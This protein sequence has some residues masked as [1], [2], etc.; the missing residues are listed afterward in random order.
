V[1]DPGIPQAPPR[2]DTVRL[3]ARPGP[4]RLEAMRA[5]L[6]TIEACRSE[7]AGRGANVVSE[8][9][10]GQGT[11]YEHDHYP[12]G[13]VY[14][15]SSHAQYYYHAHRG[16]GGEHGH[17]HCFL[18]APGMPPGVA[19]LDHPGGAGW[20]QGADAIAHLVAIAMDGDGRPTRLFTT[21]RWVTGET[22]YPAGDV[23]A[24]LDRFRIDQDWPSP[25]TNRWLG[26]M[27]VLFRLEIEALLLAR[28]RTIALWQARHPGQD[29]LEARA[30]EITSACRISLAERARALAGG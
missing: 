1:S 6:A 26:A 18:R 12:K 13:D 2:P 22:W 9:L 4:A 15:P 20:P 10:A 5:A 21:N 24:M 28:D 27:L 25:A 11:F 23:I 3:E 19:P 29:V 17:F 8:V 7:L 14:D 16:A 30:L